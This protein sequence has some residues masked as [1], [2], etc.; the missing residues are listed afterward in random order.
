MA[1]NTDAKSEVETF[2]RQLN[3]TWL[4]SRFDDL[5]QF[6]DDEV[7]MRPPG[8]KGIM[9]GREGMVESFRKFMQE[10]K[11]HG[12]TTDAI[13]VDVVSDTAV[14]NLDFE[15]DY[16]YQG[17]RYKERGSEILVWSRRSGS[18]RIVWRTQLPA[19]E[20]V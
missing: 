12:F 17:E 4:E 18:W 14:T 1:V 16:E 15:I 6:F 9:V 2:V 11:V 10:A 5:H 3:T 19:T 8:M 7:I 20:S 13:T